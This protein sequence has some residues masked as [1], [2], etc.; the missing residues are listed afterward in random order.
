[1]EEKKLYY[2]FDYRHHKVCTVAMYGQLKPMVIVGH[3]VLRV[4]YK[5]SSKKEIDTRHTS[6]YVMDEVFYETNKVIRELLG[7]SYNNSRKDLIELSMPELGKQ[8]RI[9]YNCAEI[10]SPRYDDQVRVLLQRDPT[11]RG[12]AIIMKRDTTSG[13]TW[14]EEEE[15]EAIAKKLAE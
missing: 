1:M 2:P 5:D 12:V 7:D 13:L 3:L 10:T 15:A 6:D 11:A 9:V 4:Y 14:L 8:Y